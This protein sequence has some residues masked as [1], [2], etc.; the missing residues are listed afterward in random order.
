[1]Q[2][3]TVF[4]D[5]ILSL[6]SIFVAIQIKNETSYSKSAGFIGFL[7]IGISAGLGT[8]HFL[9]IEVLDPIYRFAVGFA[10]F[11]GVPLIGT[12]FF[13]IGIKKLKKN[14]LYPVGGV[15]LSFYLIFGYIFPLPIVSTVLGGISMITAILVCIRKNSGEN[16]VP[17]LYGIL[18]A[19]LFILAGLV[20]GTSGSRGPV[21]NVD[22]FHVVLA[23]AVYSL[24]AS[25]KRL[26]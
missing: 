15:L 16:K 2:L 6:V 9:G 19:I 10:S 12:G 14:N 18:G 24:G 17:A 20:I 25:L 8:I 23:V 21:L 11:V 5:F 4:S 13:H 3:T 22:I 26:N 1:M 7:A